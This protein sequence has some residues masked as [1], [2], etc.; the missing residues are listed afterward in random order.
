MWDG[1]QIAPEDAHYQCAD[2]RGL[3]PHHRKFEMLRAGEWRPMN[4]AGKFP[5][6]RIS[7]LYAPDW[8]WGRI[9]TDPMEG[10]LSAKHDLA[11]MQAFKNKRPG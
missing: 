3:I 5:G 9:V 4:P 10:F 11:K 2:C 8:S 6:F 7:R 1:T